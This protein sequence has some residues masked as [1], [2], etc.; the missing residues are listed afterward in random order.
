MSAERHRYEKH[1]KLLVNELNHRVKNTLA[2]VQSIAAL[3]LKN[4]DATARADFEQR[5][6]SLSAPRSGTTC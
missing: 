2:I 4:N 1:L 5:L 6:L 3:T